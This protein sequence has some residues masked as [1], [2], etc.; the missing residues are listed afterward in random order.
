MLGV[1]IMLV[2]NDEHREKLIS[3]ANALCSMVFSLIGMIMKA[4]PSE[5]SS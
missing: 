4:S 1:A 5:S 2:K 3:G